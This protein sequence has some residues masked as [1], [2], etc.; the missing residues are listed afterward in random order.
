MAWLNSIFGGSTAANLIAI[1][2]GLVLVLLGLFWVFRK[3]AGDNSIRGS[4]SRRP[5]LG[6]TEAAIVDDKRRLVLVRRDNVEHLVLIGGASDVLIERNIV[7][8]QPAAGAAEPIKAKAMT[9]PQED[10]V[11]AESEIA[12]NQDDIPPSGV[13]ALASGA[14]ATAAVVASI[15]KALSKTDDLPTSDAASEDVTSKNDIEE[16]EFTAAV[17]DTLAEDA[18]P[19]ADDV[20]KTESNIPEPAKTTPRTF[21]SFADKMSKIGNRN[22]NKPESPANTASEKIAPT[23]DAITDKKPLKTQEDDKQSKSKGVQSEPKD[24]EIK[25]KSISEIDDVLKETPSIAP[26]AETKAPDVAPPLE[27]AAMVSNED[28]V[29]PPTEKA[30]DARSDDME[31]EMQKLLS[32]LAGE[33]R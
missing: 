32:E 17:A 9:V 30:K 20:M 21:E 8:V 33:R 15:E 26:E 4:K 6:V 13:G 2:V 25:M 23:V 10:D 11:L 27:V 3:I 16:S 12:D 31:D 5:R 29:K 1:T 14:A 18:G 24:V 22:E 28:P 7:R 19:I